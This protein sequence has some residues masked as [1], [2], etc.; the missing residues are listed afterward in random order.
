MRRWT[1]ELCPYEVQ[2][3]DR[4]KVPALRDFHM[5]T[6][7]GSDQ[8]VPA[9]GPRPKERDSAFMEAVGYVATRIFGKSFD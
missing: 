8:M 1:C 4:D 5:R 3:E 6:K 9:S 7:H 2:D